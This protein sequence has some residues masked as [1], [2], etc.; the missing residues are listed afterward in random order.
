MSR[1]AD[2][3]PTTPELDPS[4]VKG[5]LRHDCGGVNIVVSGRT[6]ASVARACNCGG[7]VGN[8]GLILSDQE[9]SA[10]IQDALCLTVKSKFRGEVLE[11][12][13]VWK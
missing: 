10:R 7:G 13:L 12:D 8:G 1:H 4:R 5:A 6:V 2:E 3:K 9:G 11:Q